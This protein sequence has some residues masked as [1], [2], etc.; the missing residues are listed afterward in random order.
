MAR[1]VRRSMSSRMKKGMMGI[2]G[3]IFKVMYKLGDERGTSRNDNASTSETQETF[4]NRRGKECED[5]VLGEELSRSSAPVHFGLKTK[6]LK[7]ECANRVKLWQ[8]SNTADRFF[9]KPFENVLE[10]FTNS[11]G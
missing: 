6:D 9:Y 10:M 2:G 8:R 1:L 5:G 4:Q 7:N 11:I 3:G